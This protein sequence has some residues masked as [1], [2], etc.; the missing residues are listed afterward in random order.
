MGSKPKSQTRRAGSI[1]SVQS[2]SPS[3]AP[4]A[5]D[6]HLDPEVRSP[7]DYAADE[8]FWRS[9]YQDRPYYQSGTEYSDYE[10]AYRCGYE[11]ARRYSSKKFEEIVSEVEREWNKVKGESR[12]AWEH[13]REAVHDAW[14]RVTRS[15]S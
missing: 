11:H 12:L 4:R 3:S 6:E 5:I 2:Q 7:A 14:K 15:R 9:Q 8:E 13:A 10:P 1:N